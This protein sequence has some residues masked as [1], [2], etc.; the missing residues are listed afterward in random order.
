MCSNWDQIM[1]GVFDFF[2]QLFLSRWDLSAFSCWVQTFLLNLLLPNQFGSTLHDLILQ[3]VLNMELPQRSD[4]F[5][6]T[7]CVLF[8]TITSV[9]SFRAPG[10]QRPV[11]RRDR[12]YPIPTNITR[13]FSK[14]LAPP[15]P[16]FPPRQTGEGMPNSFFPLPCRLV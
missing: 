6:C 7:S 9:P 8:L 12:P 4:P 2:S 14:C 10:S 3:F 11:D 16:C 5:P 15:D 1:A 13:T